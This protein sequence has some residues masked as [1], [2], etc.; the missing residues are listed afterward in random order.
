MG[1]TDIIKNISRDEVKSLWLTTIIKKMIISVCRINH[2][3]FVEL[4][5]KLVPIFHQDSQIL[6]LKLIINLENT[7]DKKLNKS[8]Y[9]L[10]LKELTIIIMILLST[11]FFFL[12]GGMSSRL[13][14]DKKKEDLFM[15]FFF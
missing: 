8:T 13:F 9:Y 2:D 1:K 11:C 10:V 4:I 5:K 6:E 12:G 15:E 3:E 14:Q 7:E